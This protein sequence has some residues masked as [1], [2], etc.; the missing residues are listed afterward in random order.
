M[1]REEAEEKLEAIDFKYQELWSK[2]LKYC[3]LCDPDEPCK[4]GWELITAQKHE[5]LQYEIY[6]R[7]L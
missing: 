1:N 5:R 2:H 3:G 4:V 7:V 6:C